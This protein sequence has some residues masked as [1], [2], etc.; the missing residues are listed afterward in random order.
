MADSATETQTN[1]APEADG[2]FDNFFNDPKFLAKYPGLR[3]PP[4]S[5]VVSGAQIL[6]FKAGHCIELAFPVRQNQTNPIGTLQGGVLASFFDDA[7]G[8]LCFASVLK[9]CVS[10]DLTVN[11]CR[12]ARPGETVKINAQFKSKSRKLLQLYAEA[13]NEKDKLLATATSNL[14]IYEEWQ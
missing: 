2:V 1:F 10:I 13:R 9:P 4:S 12:P 3:L 11:F 6:A 5:F 8:T 14:Q 7:F